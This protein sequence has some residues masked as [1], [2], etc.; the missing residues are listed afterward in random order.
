MI[1]NQEPDSIKYS[2]SKELK[3]L[4]RSLLI[5]SKDKRPSINDILK[6]PLVEKYI[7]RYK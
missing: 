4:V 1:L 7:N 6:I 5:K 2:F 3:D